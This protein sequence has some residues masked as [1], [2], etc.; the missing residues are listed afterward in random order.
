[1]VNADAPGPMPLGV[2]DE[3]SIALCRAWMFHLGA[4]DTVIASG[5]AREVCDLFSSCYLAWVDNQRGN[6][7]SQ[8]V[9]R[10]A[11]LA[12]NDGRRPIIFK[13]G[14]IRLDAQ[15]QADLRGVALFYY[16]PA[17]G[18]LE[19]ANSLGHQL[20]ASGLSA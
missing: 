5:Q 1:M 3:G 6:L 11:M 15:R 18:I 19:G 4:S 20:R 14:G 8:A 17:D 16:A 2:S 13:R 12:S 7:E 9:E 10:A